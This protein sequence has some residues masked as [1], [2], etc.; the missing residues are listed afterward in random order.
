MLKDEVVLEPL[1]FRVGELLEYDNEVRGL[2]T[3]SPMAL[4]WETELASWTHSWLHV[5]QFFVY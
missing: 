3:S 1:E 2:L 4:T 5:N